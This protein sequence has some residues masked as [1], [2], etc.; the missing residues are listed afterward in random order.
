MSFLDEILNYKKAVSEILREQEKIEYEGAVLYLLDSNDFCKVYS[1]YE[2]ALAELKAEKIERKNSNPF[3]KVAKLF[4]DYENP[5][6]AY[7]LY[8]KHK[9]KNICDEDNVK[10]RIAAS[11]EIEKNKI[12]KIARNTIKEH[13]REIDEVLKNKIKEE[14]NQ[15]IIALTEMNNFLL[16]N[17]DK[18]EIVIS[19]YRKEHK[20]PTIK[21]VN[22]KQIDSIEHL[23]LEVPNIMHC[24]SNIILLNESLEVKES[25]ISLD[26]NIARKNSKHIQ[27]MVDSINAFADIYYKFR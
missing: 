10:K 11:Y 5:I 8:V 19:T 22:V 12:E 23:R 3:H 6:I 4:G 21:T 26:G 9:Y 18:L 17:F 15:K 1:L 20:Y 16:A 14:E 7:K 25:Q 27:F 13:G 24:H 2:N